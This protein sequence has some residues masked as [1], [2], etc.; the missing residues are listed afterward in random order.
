MSNSS[1]R[2]YAFFD[3][4]GTILKGKPMLDFLKFYYQ[5]R[6]RNFRMLGLIKYFQFRTRSFLIGLVNRS[7]ELQNKLY[8]QCFSGQPIL[9]LQSVGDL[10]FEEM[11]TSES[12]QLNVVEELNQHKSNGAII[13]LVSGSF[14]ACLKSLA[15]VL[16]VDFTLCTELETVDGRCTGRLAHKPIIGLGKCEA[17]NG[18]ISGKDSV[19]LDKCFAYGDHGSDVHMLSMV[20]NSAVIAGDKWL[21]KVAEQ[22]GWRIISPN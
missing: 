11:I 10:W 17:I 14:T 4:D 6:Y 22:N 20:G 1:A 13:V 19:M 2:Y 3:V 16:N 15:Q 7:R 12:Y 21:E 9:Y 18:L 8:Y 5:T